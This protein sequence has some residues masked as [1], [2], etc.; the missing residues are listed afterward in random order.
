MRQSD[1][2][3]QVIAIDGAWGE[4]K[5]TVFGFVRDALNKECHKV[6]EFNPWRYQDEDTMIRAFALGIAGT[7]GVEIRNKGEQWVEVVHERGELFEGAS[8]IFALG[9][10]GRLF[11]SSATILRLTIEQLMDRVKS[12]LNQHGLRVTILVDDSD[13]LEVNQLLG[14]FRLIKLTADFEWLTFILAMDCD[15][16][17]RMVGQRFGGEDEGKRFLEKIVQVPIRLPAIPHS[18]LKEFTLQLIQTVINDLKIEIDQDEVNRF[19]GAFD[20]SLMPLIR[21]PR[22]AKQYAN[23]LRFGL[24]LLPGEVNPVDVMLLEGIRIFKPE[25]FT[26]IQEHLLVKEESHWMASL[27]ENRNDQATQRLEKLFPKNKEGLDE[28]MRFTLIGLFPDK[29]AL[30][31]HGEATFLEWTRNKRVACDEYLIRYFAATV[32]ENDVPDTE[33]KTWIELAKSTDGHELTPSIAGSLNPKSETVLVQKLRR[34]ENQLNEQQRKNFARSIAHISDRFTWR[35]LAGQWEVAFGQAAI[36]VAQCIE[37]MSVLEEREAVALDVL[38][39]AT[40]EMW[41]IEVFHRLPHDREDERHELSDEQKARVFSKDVSSRLEAAL[42]NRL[43]REIEE[44]GERPSIEFLRRSLRI[45]VKHVDKVRIQNWSQKELINDPH[46]IGPFASLFTSWSYGDQ[47][48]QQWRGDDKTLSSVRDYVDTDWLV[49]NFVPDPPA[50]RN[51]WDSYI[52]D[53]EAAYNL[54]ELLKSAQAS[55]GGTEVDHP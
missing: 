33:I 41:A 53:A 31:G 18:K 35:D 32:P 36:F 8:S 10:V 30:S 5:T 17:I 15:A 7:L 29:L 48:Q 12:E 45:C 47:R 46:F 54:I 38:A 11:R 16:I 40:S 24:G 9:A 1:P 6:M 49:Q 39:S 50:K 43:M 22:T 23:V 52:S 13:R 28:G 25:L 42:A 37:K 19:R 51:R 34:I 27:M 14:L 26:R 44:A 3:P 4:G 20:S 2:A 55:T 21:T